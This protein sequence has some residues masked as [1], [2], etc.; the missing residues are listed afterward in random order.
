VSKDKKKRAPWITGA[1]VLLILVTA[2]L[3]LIRLVRGPGSADVPAGREAGGGRPAGGEEAARVTPVRISR[4]SLGTVENSVVISGDVLPISQVS[5]YPVMAGKLVELRVRPGDTVRRGEVVAVVDPSRPGDHFYGSPVV[6][7][8]SGSVLSVPV[9]LGETLGTGSAV[10]L[11]G[12]LSRLR[13]ETYVPERYSVY[14]RPGLPGQI[15]FEAMP[16]EIFPAEVDELAPALDPASRTR[17]IRLRFIPDA[18][19]RVDPRILS[20][21]FATV[22]LV[23]NAHVDVPV[24]PR[25]SLINTYGSWIVFTVSPEGRAQRREVTLGLESE[26]TVEITSGL[27]PGEPVVT[28]GQ[29]FLNDGDPVRVV[30]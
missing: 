5:I 1:L 10:C 8:V 21:M 26:E 14:M 17:M 23:T 9:N 11:V 25:N 13:V 16:G 6:S 30:E 15:S 20:G 12:D 18:G 27:E 3:I 19:G 24:I 4:V 7:T 22:S 29:N 28:A 2:A